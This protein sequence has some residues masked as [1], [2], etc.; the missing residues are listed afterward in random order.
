MME[1]FKILCVIIFFV[2]AIYYYY[3]FKYEFWKKRKVI[4]PKPVL[5][6]GTMKDV[7]LRRTSFME[8]YRSIYIAYKDAPLVGMFNQTMP[9]L[10]INDFSLI[11]E[12]M[13]NVVV[14][15]GRGIKYSKKAE[16][17]NH[18]LF[19]MNG[20]LPLQLRARLSPIFAP[21]K[22]KNMYPLLLQRSEIFNNWL[23]TQLS[24]NEE[25]D[26]TKIITRL[27]VDYTTTCLFGYDIT[28]IEDLDS[29]IIQYIKKHNDIN[30]LKF[31]VKTLLPDFV[32]HNKIYDLIGY[33]LFDNSKTTEHFNRFLKNIV[34]YRKEHDILKHDIVSIFM[35]LKQKK[36][37]EEIEFTD[38][39]FVAQMMVC[40]TAAYESSTATISHTL[41]E[42]ALN[43]SIQNKLREEIRNLFTKNNG[44][45][46]FKDVMTMPYLDAVY[47]E[48]LRKYPVADIIM[49]QSSTAY[50]FTNSE[51]TI[52]K[53]QIVIIPVYGIH[54]NPEIYPKPENYDPER[55]IGEE[56]P[57]RQA[58]HFIPFGHGPRNCIGERFGITQV[59]MGLINIVRNYKIDL[60]EK[61]HEKICRLESL[62]QQLKHI[63]LKISKID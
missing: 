23:D 38:D 15:S 19:L 56:A 49:R 5:C 42:I 28:N 62:V 7:I 26:C 51:V 22:L 14:F 27:V 2:C 54:F 37:M 9:I 50:T 21:N 34:N 33:Y 40:F 32:I 36:S 46:T 55:F 12:V 47:K 61:T 3:T 8:H 52:P 6:F 1:I 41:Y 48:T 24:Q 16:P 60:C 63:Y 43:H 53:D 30:T 39:F 35:E 45:L 25:V 58:M 18:N 20:K 44:E 57:S 17:M 31:M 10:M 4:G 11:K 13:T 59:K 29:E